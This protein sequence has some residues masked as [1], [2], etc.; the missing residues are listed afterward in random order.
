MRS[1]F[2]RIFVTFGVAAAAIGAILVALALT[3][4]PRRAVFQ[5]HEHQLARLGAELLSAA[6]EGAAP[7]GAERPR[8]RGGE[9]GAF[10]FRGAEGPLGGGRAPPAVR[11]L[12]SE[13]AATGERRVRAGRNG[14]WLALPLEDDYVL[15]AQV[16][17]PSRLER[18]LDPYGLVLRLGAAL[19]VVLAV[20]WFLARSLA[21]P[22]RELRRATRRLASGDLGARVAASLGSR[23]DETAE[24]GRDFDRMA[25]RIEELL[26]A[27]QRLLRDI[28]H[29]LRSPLARLGVALELARQKAGPEADPPLDRIGREAERLNELIGQLLTLTRLEG[30][31]ELPAREE[32]DLAELVGEVA[33]DADF[34]AR[35]RGCTV[36]VEACEPARVVGVPELLR[37]AVENVVRNAVRFTAEGTAVALS[38][39]QSAA[40]GA[41][42][43]VCDQGPGLPEAALAEV[44][45]PFYRVADARDRGSG[46]AGLGLAI[47]ERA[48]RLHGGA[49]RAEN[50]PEGGLRVTIELPARA[51][52]WSQPLP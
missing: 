1:L 3:T 32:V 49:I 4:D 43:E 14:L 46:G 26:E 11:R 24:L 5:R 23:R 28:S 20:S 40:G 47:A 12:A 41:R 29:E 25:A 50:Q 17:P 45:R 9:P 52:S 8:P 16:P 15:V 6:R 27:Q 13:T 2:L 39:R 30:A 48:V 51:P 19:A 34:E 21:A 36:R 42:I 33:R 18:L 37:R 44:F 10:L 7:P 35:A 22:I 31:G 38:L